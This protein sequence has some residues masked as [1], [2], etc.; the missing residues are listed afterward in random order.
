[1]KPQKSLRDVAHALEQATEALDEIQRRAIYDKPAEL[2]FEQKVIA[3]VRF[4]ENGDPLN[5][6]LTYEEVEKAIR[7]LADIYTV[8]GVVMP[9]DWY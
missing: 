9:E 2:S 1:M 7:T 6:F 4:M 8:T 5:D 3:S